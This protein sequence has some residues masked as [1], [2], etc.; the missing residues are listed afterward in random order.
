MDNALWGFGWLK[1]QLA[2]VNEPKREQRDEKL[3]APVTNIAFGWNEDE[4]L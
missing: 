1:N 4:N 2:K 3:N